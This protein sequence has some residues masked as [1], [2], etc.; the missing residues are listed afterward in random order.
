L[1]DDVVGLF[2]EN[3][4]HYLAG[5]PLYNLVDAQKGY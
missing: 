2:A 1:L 5:E 4:R 3:L